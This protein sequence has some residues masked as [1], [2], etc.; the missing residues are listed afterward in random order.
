MITISAAF[1]VSICN[2]C[3]LSARVSLK[4]K[5]LPKS[6]QCATAEGT[7][8][9]SAAC[10]SML[11]LL[12]SKQA[13]DKHGRCLFSLQILILWTDVC[14]ATAPLHLHT[15]GVM[16]GFFFWFVFFE[17]GSF[18]R[19]VF[20]VSLSLSCFPHHLDSLGLTRQVHFAQEWHQESINHPLSPFLF[21]LS[22][23]LR[24]GGGGVHI[25]AYSLEV[26]LCFKPRY[27]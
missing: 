2:Y 11:H 5:R 8:L 22:L 20:I 13:R 12:Q 15:V 17:G 4:N 1:C 25:T 9:L 10:V 19:F 7:S 3:F 27:I 16:F 23:F 26:I 6:N 21:F 14:I 18:F 24:V